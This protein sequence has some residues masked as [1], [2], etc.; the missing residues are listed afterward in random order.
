MCGQSLAPSGAPLLLMATTL[1]ASK[2][3]V[4]FGRREMRTLAREVSLVSG[5]SPGREFPEMYD[6]K[7]GPLVAWCSGSILSLAR[8][9]P[10]S[11]QILPPTLP[12]S[13]GEPQHCISMLHSTDQVIWSL[14]RF[15]YIYKKTTFVR[16]FVYCFSINF[17]Q[18]EERAGKL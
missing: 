4:A 15:V 18:L 11:I 7:V 14:P 3:P 10:F 8:S 2:Q 1:P 13:P 16:I 6:Q 12:P 17:L 5:F 9:S